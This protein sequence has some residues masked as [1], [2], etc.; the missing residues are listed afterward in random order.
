M[1]PVVA[2]VG[3]GAEQVTSAGL[4]RPANLPGR[5][6]SGISSLGARTK[7]GQ[8][9]RRLDVA[10][11]LAVDVEALPTGAGSPSTL[12]LGIDAQAGDEGE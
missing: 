12:A 4:V 6:G 3:D 5:S 9:A 11:R 10:L 2:D 8:R 1:S 7:E